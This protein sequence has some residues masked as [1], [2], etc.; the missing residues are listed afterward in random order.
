[1][2]GDATYERAQRLLASLDQDLGKRTLLRH[3]DAGEGGGVSAGTLVHSDSRNVSQSANREE[4]VSRGRGGVPPNVDLLA[5]EG[6]GG[7]G[8]DVEEQVIVFDFVRNDDLEYACEMAREENNPSALVQRYSLCCSNFVSRSGLGARERNG[9]SMDFQGS[10]KGLLGQVEAAI[11]E[12]TVWDLLYYLHQPRQYP[13]P[14]DAEYEEQPITHSKTGQERV[15]YVYRQD[16]DFQLLHRVCLWLHDTAVK[17]SAYEGVL[18][19][20]KDIGTVSYYPKTCA[21]VKGDLQDYTTVGMTKTKVVDPDVKIRQNVQ[22][23]P[24]DEDMRSSFLDY[25]WALIRTGAFYHSFYISEPV[26]AKQHVDSAYAYATQQATELCRTFAEPWRAASLLGGTPDRCVLRAGVLVREGNVYRAIWKQCCLELVDRFNNKDTTEASIYALA[27]GDLDF[28]LG[29]PLC[30]SW[31]DKCWAYFRCLVQAK[32]DEALL[33]HRSSSLNKTPN[34]AG[35]VG[36]TYEQELEKRAKR[37]VMLK[38]AIVFSGLEAC[39]DS[40]VETQAKS[41]HHRLQASLILGTFHKLL[42][43]ELCPFYCGEDWILLSFRTVAGI[44]GEEYAS[45]HMRQVISEIEKA[46]S[47]TYES[48]FEG[49]EPEEAPCW[50]DPE[51]ATVA[52]NILR[53]LSHLVLYMDHFKHAHAVAKEAK[54][55]NPIAVIAVLTAYIRFLIAEKKFDAVAFFFEDLP[56][57]LC[58]AIFA[59]IL[60]ALIFADEA[61]KCKC[62]NEWTVGVTEVELQAMIMRCF[63]NVL[64]QW[65]ARRGP[66][67]LIASASGRA[68]GQP[69]VS[70]TSE[71]T[72]KQLISRLVQAWRWFLLVPSLRREGIAQANLLLREFMDRFNRSDTSADEK[73]IFWRTS[74]EVV[75][76]VHDQALMDIAKASDQAQLSP[77]HGSDVVQEL[78][79]WTLYIAALSAFREWQDHLST[80]EAELAVAAKARSCLGW[81]DPARAKT[82]K[83]SEEYTDTA[84]LELMRLSEFTAKTVASVLTFRHGWLVDQFP[85]TRVVP[86]TL[87][88]REVARLIELRDSSLGSLQNPGHTK[89]SCV[90]KLV[91]L[92]HKVLVRTAQAL[93]F[94]CKHTA[95]PEFHLSNTISLFQQSLL[96]AD[97]VADN[98]HKLYK[99]YS[100]DDSAVLLSRLQHSAKNVMRLLG[101]VQVAQP[102]R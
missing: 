76:L 49:K 65:R 63:L 23:H 4:H 78:E 88:S 57:T 54:E 93:E 20:L 36:G 60:E 42:I 43:E 79:G 28:L 92:C 15:N 95:R 8:V 73:E 99:C 27:A 1:M 61:E 2:K 18:A 100:R 9:G 10:S 80:V 46:N 33:D 31:L 30:K 39:G 7:V 87:C 25:L 66:C 67:R 102:K 21:T 14:E 19:K 53:L 77:I 11:Q 37:M 101:R 59:A 55:L 68:I 13:G 70:G 74:N 24:D 41:W 35:P 52:P 47:Q 5:M 58:H 98:K 16:L 69:E 50:S 84:L 91:L 71:W 32:V 45:T 22:I 40:L 44:C 75:A 64:N 51:V 89:R 90:P 94:H 12:R 38:P 48:L 96:L 72:E 62:L 56:K 97:V 17:S 85:T 6:A 29:S 83:A 3:V 81:N 86:E 82:S 34:V 26:E